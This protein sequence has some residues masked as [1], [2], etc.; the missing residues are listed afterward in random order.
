MTEPKP[1]QSNLF[2]RTEMNVSTQRAISMHPEHALVL[3]PAVTYT[4]SERVPGA[5]SSTSM[6][7]DRSESPNLQLQLLQPREINLAPSIRPE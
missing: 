6:N 2:R 3:L 7:S 4:R 5:V 1:K